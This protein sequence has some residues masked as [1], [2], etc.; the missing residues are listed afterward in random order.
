MPLLLYDS[1]LPHLLYEYLN[2][3]AP[4]AWSCDTYT[5]DNSADSKQRG[6]S[7]GYFV[8][9]RD[10]ERRVALIWGIR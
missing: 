2:K 1:N 8:Y 4:S 5:L 3:G 10:D 7:T 9:E 6:R